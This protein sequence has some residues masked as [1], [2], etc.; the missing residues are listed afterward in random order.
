MANNNACASFRGDADAHTRCIT[1][2][3]P[4]GDRLLGAYQG[5][6]LHHHDHDTHRHGYNDIYWS[7]SNGNIDIHNNGPGNNLGMS[8]A[9]DAD[10]NGFGWDR[11]T[12]E[13]AVPSAGGNETRSKNVAVNF[14]IKICNC[15]TENC[16]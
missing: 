9:Q 1:S 12:D 14:Y 3:D 5:D 16:R 10:N 7:E 11:H 13:S 8:V 2:R 15:R 6:H 4:D